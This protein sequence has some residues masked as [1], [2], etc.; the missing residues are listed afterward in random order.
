MKSPDV[1]AGGRPTSDTAARQRSFPRPSAFS[2]SNWPVSRRLVAVIVMAVVM[3][4][5]FGG[6]RVAVSVDSATGFARTTQLALLGQQ[7]TQLAQAMEDERDTSAGVVAYGE[8]TPMPLP[9][10]KAVT[11]LYAP[12]QKQATDES[13]E[14]AAKQHLTDQIAKRVQ[15]L[16][17]GI[18]TSFPQ[19]TQA[20]AQ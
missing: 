13:T 15:T 7:V 17:V 12:E 9:P 5:V 20:K 1:P 16:A 3:G 14:L 8:I 10:A 2:L 11:R 4:L 18:G 19:N 6:L